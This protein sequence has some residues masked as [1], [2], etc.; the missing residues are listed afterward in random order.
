[1]GLFSRKRGTDPS[2]A[3]SDFWRW[4][5]RSGMS[6]S[7]TAV[8]ASDPSA[9][10]AELTTRVDS[11]SRSLTWRFEAGTESMHRLV[12]T[13][14]DPQARSVARR[15]LRAAPESDI[16]WSY[17]DMTLPASDVDSAVVPI[18]GHD[19][20][21]A[22]ARVAVRRTPLALD[23]QLYH[24]LLEQLD[25]QS[26]LTWCLSALHTALG[27]VLVDCWLGEVTPVHSEPM[28]A[29]GLRGLQTVIR[30]LDE[31]F[32]GGQWLD[33]RGQGPAGSA[34]G[35][36]QLP[37]SSLKHPLL[38]ECVEVHVP[39]DKDSEGLPGEAD[40]EEL[41]RFEATLADQLDGEGRLVASLASGGV[42][43]SYFYVDPQ[44]T[45]AAQIDAAARQWRTR[46]RVVRNADPGWF[47]VAHL[48]P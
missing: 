45:G 9:V 21:L 20:D 48:R 46:T 16:Y 11:I 12:V 5:N 2:G 31:E 34:V 29:F 28:D 40:A 6:A 17:A 4:W 27:D 13:T 37:F 43:T 25:E 24:P 22:Q 8:A 35:K 39:Y 38:D 3:I 32:S 26:Q 1:M 23:V 30:D 15:W 10:N 7:S 41:T 18:A 44:R 47:R 19:L 14:S 33:L 42:W 36:V